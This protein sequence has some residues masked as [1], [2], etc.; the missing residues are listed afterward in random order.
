MLEIV[1]QY[2]YFGHIFLFWQGASH[3]GDYH[4]DLARV[5]GKLDDILMSAEILQCLPTMIYGAETWIP[6]A[7]TVQNESCT[8]SHEAYHARH[9]T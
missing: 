8:W 3:I 2:I 5:L 1:D 6:T 9:Q 7:E 4:K